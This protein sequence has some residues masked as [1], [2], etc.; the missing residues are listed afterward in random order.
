[1]GLDELRAMKCVPCESGMPALT[2]DE[3]D[4]YRRQ[5]EGWTSDGQKIR[6]SFA[7]ANFRSAM[8]F[9]NE[10]ARVAEEEGHHPDFTLHS[11]NKVDVTLWTH[12]IGGLSRNDFIVAAKIDALLK[13]RGAP[14]RPSP[15]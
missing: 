13:E 4:G 8:A 5:V 14:Q 15:A 10:L 2:K 3:A 11:W 6:K 12:A 9:L 7:F 1:M